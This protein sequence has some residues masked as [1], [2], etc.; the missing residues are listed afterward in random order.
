MSGLNGTGV[1]TQPASLQEF[2]DEGVLLEACRRKLSGLL[3]RHPHACRGI[4]VEK[5][6]EFG[7]KERHGK[8]GVTLIFK[9]RNP[10]AD[11]RQIVTRVEI[12]E[13]PDG[14]TLEVTA[15][16]FWDDRE[17]A[18]ASHVFGQLTTEQVV[19]LLTPFLTTDREKVVKTSD[20]ERAGLQLLGA[21]D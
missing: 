6:G 13:N 4:I 18:H 10:D 3:G 17:N 20:I 19:Q 5:A 15:N 9:R 11:G 14:K 1:S 2:K 16:D 21:M 12:A 7:V 8:S